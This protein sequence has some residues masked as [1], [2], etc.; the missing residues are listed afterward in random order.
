MGPQPRYR[1]LAVVAFM[2][3]IALA[4]AVAAI[5]AFDSQGLKKMRRLIHGRSRCPR[6]TPRGM[7]EAANND[8]SGAYK[9]GHHQES[10]R[11]AGWAGLG[12]PAA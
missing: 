8:R 2:C 9:H 12:R 1:L 11:L 10:P 7:A 5:I 4:V 3:G 6:R